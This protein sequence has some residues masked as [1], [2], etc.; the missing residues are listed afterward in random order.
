MAKTG[1]FFSW[2]TWPNRQAIEWLCLKFAPE[3]AKHRGERIVIVGAGS[4]AFPSGVPGNVDL[5]G[6]S[7]REAVEQLY[8]GC[9]LFVAPI[10]NS[11]GSK[12]KLLRCLSFGTPFLA[13]RNALSGLR[14]LDAP[15]N[16]A[17]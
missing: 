13:T 16:P 11:H 2:A 15:L 6:P 4:D 17:Q 1:V 14:G 12:I 7:T 10:A 5:L 8:Q 3:F 9:G